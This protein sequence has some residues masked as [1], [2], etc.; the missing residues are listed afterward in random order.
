M[1]LIY[2]SLFADWLHIVDGLRYCM[3]GNG[4]NL[5]T[6]VRNWGKLAVGPDPVELDAVCAFMMGQDPR[7][8]PYLDQA[9]RALKG[10]DPGIL[11]QVPSDFRREFV[12]NDKVLAWMESERKHRPSLYYLKASGFLRNRFPGLAR[13]L[14]YLTRPLRRILRDPRRQKSI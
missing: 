9:S 3:E 10:F 12:L 8:L 7:K 1:D 5:G 4:P 11:A 6:T 14:A 13:L 2:F